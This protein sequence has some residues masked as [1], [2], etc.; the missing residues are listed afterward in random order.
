MRRKTLLTVVFTIVA[1]AASASVAL[2]ADPSIVKAGG[3]Q[4][5]LPEGWAKVD[6]ANEPGA[7]DPRTLLVVGT[8]G[9]RP[10]AT[11]CQVASYRVPDDGAVVVVV[12]WSAAYL[13]KPKLELS[14]LRKPT[15]ACFDGRGAVGQV[16]RKGRDYQ[17]SVMVGDNA[18][19][20][21]IRDALAVA[22]SFALVAR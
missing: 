17:V 8:K 19:A 21:T 12:G 1:L 3:V 22:R 6:R 16:T 4:L 18:S 5:E 14:K 7:S 10:V 2:A 15:F 20:E 13:D 11:P 9:A